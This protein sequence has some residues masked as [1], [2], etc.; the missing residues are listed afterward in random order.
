[1][2]IYLLFDKLRLN[3]RNYYYIDIRNGLENSSRS[4]QQVYRIFHSFNTIFNRF[5]FT[6]LKTS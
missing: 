5:P 6:G 1:M 4:N 2:K 3:I